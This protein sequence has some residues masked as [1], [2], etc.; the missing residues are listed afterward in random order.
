MSKAE[1]LIGASRLREFVEKCEPDKEVV[2][3]IDEWWREHRPLMKVISLDEW[4]ERK[5]Q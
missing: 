3:M 4:R 1:W 5:R 2:N